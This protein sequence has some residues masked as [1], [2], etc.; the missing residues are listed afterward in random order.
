MVITR[1][2]AFL[3]ATL[4]LVG[5]SASAARA[6]TTYT[7]ANSNVTGTPTSPL[8]WFGAGQG[9]WIGGDP[10]SD[11][12]NT[13]QFFENTT[14]AL[15]N[16]ANPSTQTVNLNNGGPAF[17]LGTLTLSGLASATANANLTMTLSG[18]ALNFSAATGTINLAAI[19]ATRTITYNLNSAIE[20]G[21]ASSGSVLKIGG[22]GTSA[23][24]IGGIISELQAGGGS[25]FKSG[26]STVSLTGANTHTGTTTVNQGTLNVSGVAGSIVG[27]SGVTVNAGAMLGL[28]NSDGIVNRIK[29]DATLAL[30]GATLIFTG[31]GA[32][33]S[34][35]ETIGTLAIGAGGTTITLTGAGASQ[36]QT[37]SAA[38][39]SRSGFGTA[40]IRGTSLQTAATNS[41]RLAL[42]DSSGLALVGGGLAN[43]GTSTAGTTTTLSIAPYLIGDTSAAGTGSSFLTY[44]LSGALRPL[45]AGEY[46]TLSAD[47]TTPGTPE[48]V[49][50]FNGTLTAANPTVNS[51]RFSTATQTLQGSGTLTVNSGAIAATANTAVISGFTGITL[52]DGSWNEGVVTATGSN[53]LTIS[54]P[55]DVSGGGPLIK[56]GSGVLLL[57]AASNNYSGGTVINAGRLNVAS[58]AALGDASGSIILNGG[59][60]SGRTNTLTGSSG[61]GAINLTTA[62]NVVVT[63]AGGGIAANGNTGFTTTGALSGSGTLTFVNVGGAGGRSLNFNS[64]DNTFTGGIVIDN[65]G[66]TIAFNSLADSSNSIVFNAGGTLSYGSGAIAP[67]TLS[68]RPIEL[69]SASASTTTIQNNNTIHSI[70]IGTDL[71]A[72]GAGV[73]TLTLGAVAGPTNVFSGNISDG[74]GGGS[75]AITKTGAGTWALSGTNTYAGKTYNNSSSGTL[76]F[77]NVDQSLPSASLL[78]TA[79][80]NNQNQ[81]TR[82]LSDTSGTI[83][84]GNTVT[85]DGGGSSGTGTMTLFVGNNSVANGGTSNG[86]TTGSKIVLGTLDLRSSLEGGLVDN[87]MAARVAITGANDYT[88]EVGD[89][90][91]QARGTVSATGAFFNPTTAPLIITGTVKQN[92]GRTGAD[93][94]GLQV[95]TLDGTA[96]K[97]EIKGAIQNATDFDDDTN[98]NALPTSLTKSNISTWTLSGA[99][100]YSGGTTITTGK[101]VFDGADALPTT[102]TVAVGANGHL[103]LADGTAR[104]SSVSALTLASNANL[105]FD[106]TG[107]DTGDEL[108]SVADITPTAGSNIAVN[109]NLS[110]T[111]GGSVSLLAG[112]VGST[113]SSSNFYLAN[114]TDY[115][116]T[117]STPT[118]DT[119]VVDNYAS[120]TTLTTIYWMGNRLAAGAV[121][122]VDNAWALSNGTV[123]NWSTDS[124]TYA[125]TALTPGSTANVIFSNT[126]TGRAQQSTALASDVTVNSVVIADATAVTVAGANGATL[127]LLSNLST[128]GLVDGTPG[129]AITVTSTANANTN[130]TSRV[131]LGS[132]QTWNVASGKTLT[133][134]GEVAGG[135]SLTKADTGTVILNGTN[136]YYGN[137]TINAGILRIGN[138]TAGTLGGGNYSGNIVNNGTLQIWSTAAQTL[139]GVIS[140]SGDLVKSYTGTLTLS[141]NNT[142][143]GKTFI[144]PT[145]VSG[146]AG[147]GILSVSSFNSVNGGTPLMASSSLGAPTTVANGTIEFGTT[148]VQQAATILYTGPGETTDRVI[149]FLMNGNGA[150]KALDVS[151]SGL[152]KFTSTFT[153]TGSDNNDVTLQ[154]A[155]NGEIVGGLDFV[156]RNFTKAGAGTWTLGGNLGHTGTTTISGG[157]LE[158]NS[159]ATIGGGT[160]NNTIAFSNSSTLRYNSTA[161]QTFGGVISGAGSLV[162]DN[163]SLLTLSNTNTYSGATTVNAGTLLIDGTGSINGSSGVTVASGALLLQNSSVSLTAPLTISAGGS[164]G[165][166]G[167]IVGNFEFGVGSSLYVEDLDTPFTVSSGTVSFTGT[168]GIANLAG[169][170]WDDVAPDT[171]TLISGTVDPTN[172][173]NVGAGNSVAV[174]DGKSAYFQIGSLQLVVVPEPGT[175]ALLGAG[176]IAGVAFLRRRRRVA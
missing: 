54:S 36:L 71:I 41:T 65:N 167:E 20:L 28:N 114:L 110:G 168:F 61:G 88:L 24:N 102:G 7:W 104:N 150:T 15:P 8:D 109:L 67:L 9:T 103:S 111:P 108:T 25:L 32:T 46:T 83:T 120:Q 140:G 77:Q 138:N 158:L 97:N 85:T 152:L 39:F 143:T 164:F 98:P 166:T 73:K 66:S 94:L 58:D 51:L 45:A 125:G 31:R 59:T 33:G 69:N 6:Q 18:D 90:I 56:A 80:T 72:T 163:T 78:T 154:G 2:F 81:I 37:L 16:T 101:L 29:D 149:N 60:L 4:V 171:Y 47:Y 174:G 93:N 40:L 82:L 122:G 14:T 95:L 126:L 151:G 21:T 162:K 106:W 113:L 142:Y 144:Q 35:T 3:S 92:N 128:P 137:T 124:G 100:T 30:N 172:L 157:T 141:G 155:G 48:N 76:I 74:T 176:A 13:V 63:S 148:L 26:T 119:L 91:L 12:T 146:G 53:T 123:S 70:T 135:F 57:N 62:R 19:N 130:I 11:N 136:T 5:V 64:T 153:K 129:S 105:S 121:A 23:F 96:S 139:S 116:A 115:T 42:G 112:G 170:V 79:I 107:T 165:G 52:G 86:T 99:N 127:T 117:L 17:E 27:S 1:R 75:V 134:S 43:Q 55:V 68:N 49:N 161:D 147:A 34:A 160:Y 10:V 87:R 175:L 132:N 156:F 50:A 173:V 159:G 38:A 118:A 22:N 169:I 84:L 133:V 145:N 89:V 131:H 44:D